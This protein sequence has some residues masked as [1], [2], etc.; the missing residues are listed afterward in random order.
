MLRTLALV[1]AGAGGLVSVA[2]LLQMS[3]RNSAFPVVVVLFSIWVL[4]PFIALLFAILRSKRWP[5][6]VRSTLYGIT[7]V[8]AIASVLI[9]TRL[10]DLKPATSANTFLFVAVPPASWVAIV[11]TLLVATLAAR[12]QSRRRTGSGS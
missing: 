6:M 10:I 1:A 4:S 2:L 7:I 9:Y 5:D 8:V 11:M 12:S 3:T